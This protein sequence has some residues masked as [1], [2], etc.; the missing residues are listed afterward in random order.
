[1]ERPEE[2]GQVSTISA[3]S[4][5]RDLHGRN[6]GLVV[7]VGVRCRPIPPQHRSDPAAGQRGGGAEHGLPRP[8]R[9]L[10]VDELE[11]DLPASGMLKLPHDLVDRERLLDLEEE[12]AGRTGEGVRPAGR[13]DRAGAQSP[14]PGVAVTTVRSMAPEDRSVPIFSSTWSGIST[15][16]LRTHCSDIQMRHEGA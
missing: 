2:F 10:L 3:R 4:E 7:P 12:L 5:D 8:S 14:V 16:S 1:V 11:V 9:R 13:H 6:S 15:S